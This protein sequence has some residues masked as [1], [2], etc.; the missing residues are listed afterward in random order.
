[1]LAIVN[2]ELGIPVVEGSLLD[3]EFEYGSFDLVTMTEYLEH[4]S[5]PGDVVARAAQLV[6]PGGHVAI[7][8]FLQ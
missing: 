6:K 7:V 8:L 2:G 1:M 4:E 3:L 5:R